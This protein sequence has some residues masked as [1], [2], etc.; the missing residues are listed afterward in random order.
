MYCTDCVAHVGLEAEVLWGTEG[1]GVEIQQ[2][3]P[4]TGGVQALHSPLQDLQTRPPG[5]FKAQFS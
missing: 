1:S 5:G 3:L 4:V 2:T